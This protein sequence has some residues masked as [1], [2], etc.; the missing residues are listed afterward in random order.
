MIVKMT[1]I[2]HV[3]GRVKHYTELPKPP[4]SLHKKISFVK[5]VIRIL[6]YI[7]G[8]STFYGG[9]FGVTACV[10][11]GVLVIS[12]IIGIIEELGEK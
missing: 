4:M 3:T 9:N 10:T 2:D 8:A 7:L 11:F 12:E 1:Q 5:S 6:G